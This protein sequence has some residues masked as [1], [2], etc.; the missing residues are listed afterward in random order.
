MFRES[1]A[2]SVGQI[3]ET[4]ELKKLCLRADDGLVANIF[5][6]LNGLTW[7]HDSSTVSGIVFNNITVVINDIVEKLWSLT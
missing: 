7:Y 3:S 4:F 2:V 5:R 6:D 1:E